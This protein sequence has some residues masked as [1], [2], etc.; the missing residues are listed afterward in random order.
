MESE[1]PPKK[2]LPDRDL[3]P[4]LTHPQQTRIDDSDTFFHVLN[5]YTVYLDLP[6]LPPNAQLLQLYSLH[7]SLHT[8]KSRILPYSVLSV[9][10]AAFSTL[11]VVLFLGLAVASASRPNLYEG[12]LAY[13]LGRYQL[14]AAGQVSPLPPH[15]IPGRALSLTQT[16][17]T[18]QNS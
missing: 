7:K 18:P 9:I 8:K 14:S 1:R 13:C 2:I 12:P 3:S 16:L 10:M 5:E 6:S 17:Q 4:N 11:L 15:T